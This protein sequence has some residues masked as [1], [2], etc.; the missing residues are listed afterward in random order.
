VQGKGGK[1]GKLFLSHEE[2]KE[3]E[4]RLLKAGPKEYGG[5]KGGK[6][7]KE[8]GFGPGP[9]GGKGHGPWEME[10]RSL[11]AGAG[12]KGGKG[13]KFFDG[14]DV[15]EGDEDYEHG[16]HHGKGKGKGKGRHADAHGDHG[17]T[18]RHEHG[19]ASSRY[20]WKSWVPRSKRIPPSSA[21][22]ASLMK[23][24]GLDSWGAE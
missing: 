19:P 8:F 14:D 17:K 23:R 4:S 2:E 9:K 12:A 15:D 10:E 18:L 5:P 16:P 7:G 24:L 1:G 21:P 22:K 11:K 3:E 6:G 20:D 13:G